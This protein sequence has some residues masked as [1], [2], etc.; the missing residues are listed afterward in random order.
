MKL[1]QFKIG[2]IILKENGPTEKNAFFGPVEFLAYENG[3]LFCAYVDIPKTFVSTEHFPQAIRTIEINGKGVYILK[4]NAME[5]DWFLFPV[6]TL[7]KIKAYLALKYA[8]PESKIE[9]DREA[10]KQSYKI[11]E[12]DDSDLEPATEV[13]PSLL[14]TGLS[15]VERTRGAGFVGE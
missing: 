8:E 9:L 6:K 2:N 15:Q 10:Q 4:M 7:N 11:P 3:L 1:S 5:D 12:T 14:P 13:P